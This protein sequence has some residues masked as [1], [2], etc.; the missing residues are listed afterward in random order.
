MQYKISKEDFKK[1]Y[2][3]IQNNNIQNIN[4]K[5]Y[6]IYMK[7]ILLN[8]TSDSLMNYLIQKYGSNNIYNIIKQIYELN[9]NINIKIVHTDEIKKEDIIITNDNDNNKND[10]N[11]NDNNNNKNDDNEDYEDDDEDDDDEDEDDDDEDDNNNSNNKSQ[12]PLINLN[13]ILK[14]SNTNVMTSNILFDNNTDNNTD[15]DTNTNNFI[16]NLKKILLNNNNKDNNNKD[17][18]NKDNNDDDNDDDDDD[19]DNDNDNE[20]EKNLSFSLFRNNPI[21]VND[22]NGIN[23]IPKDTHEDMVANLKTIIEYLKHLADVLEN[24]EM[25]LLKREMQLIN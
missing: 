21:I 16:D 15:T 18:N 5:K 24:K 25:A 13:N 22:N 8:N 14:D 12:Y 2:N 6:K 3:N 11:N 19:D 17:N 9:P 23:M 7:N 1:L 4:K 10:N 20:D